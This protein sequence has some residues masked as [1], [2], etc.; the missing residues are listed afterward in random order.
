M[1]IPL[2][3][4]VRRERREKEQIRLVKMVGAEDVGFYCKHGLM[5]L[6]WPTLLEAVDTMAREEAKEL[7]AREARVAEARLKL[8]LTP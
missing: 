8:Y 3:I 1:E 2:V 4:D 7:R 6:N 5:Q